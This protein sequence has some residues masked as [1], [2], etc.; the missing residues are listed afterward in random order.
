MLAKHQGMFIDRQIVLQHNTNDVSKMSADEL[1]KELQHQLELA[2][3]IDVTP[4]DAD[5]MQTN[6]DDSS[7]NS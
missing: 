6:D 3:T 7:D 5:K 1:Q 4:A 2:N